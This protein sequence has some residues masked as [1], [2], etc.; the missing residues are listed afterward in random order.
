MSA[1]LRDKGAAHLRVVA[2]TP[3]DPASARSTQAPPDD[4]QLL[5]AMRSGDKSAA[6]A[7]YDRVRP[8]IDRTLLRLFGKRDTDHDDLRQLALMELV[9]T[10]HRFRGECSL[11]S[12]VGTITGHIVFKH[13]R[14]RQTEA[15]LFSVLD[16]EDLL[17]P[18]VHGTAREPVLRNL[19]RRTSSH[20]EA[21]QPDKSWAFVLHD[22][23][24]YDLKEL[25]Q[26]MRVSVSAA[27]TRLVRGRHDLHARIASDPELSGLLDQIEAWP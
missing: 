15:R 12:W 8:Q 22:V 23:L 7:F 24:G 27:Q 11:D 9:F 20:L 4:S 26:I 6:A 3:N 10:L 19:M 14:R 25:A 2:T 21:M 13:L 1:G 5:S 16:R 18:S 17:P